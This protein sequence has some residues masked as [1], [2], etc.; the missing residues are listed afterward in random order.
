MPKTN[1]APP[2]TPPTS[3]AT[4]GSQKYSSGLLAEYVVAHELFGADYG[5]GAYVVSNEAG[6][7][8]SPRC[9]PGTGAMR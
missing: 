1:S 3:G 9:C 6:D 8:Y 4:N 2:I 7:P 5:S